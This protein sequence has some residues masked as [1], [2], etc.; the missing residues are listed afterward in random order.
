MNAPAING[1][2]RIRISNAVKYKEEAKE[3][4]HKRKALKKK[5]SFKSY[6]GTKLWTNNAFQ[7]S[8]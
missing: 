2:I 8:K 7:N 4:E 5:S 6:A 1:E 3:N